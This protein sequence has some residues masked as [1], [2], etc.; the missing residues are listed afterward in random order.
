MVAKKEKKP[1]RK[2]KSLPAKSVSAKKAKS[3]KG[4]SF[5][6]GQKSTRMPT[7]VE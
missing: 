3:V 1:A 5:S 7:A 6:A 4:G 2:I